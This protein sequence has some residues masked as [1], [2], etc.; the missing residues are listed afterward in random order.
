MKLSP[1]DIA[2]VDRIRENA[3][4]GIEKLSRSI[5]ELGQLY[6]VLIDSDDRLIDG[7]RR[8]R[9][10]EL[11]GI[12]VEC[13]KVIHLDDAILHLKAERD[14]NDTAVPFTKSEAVELGK[15]LELLEKPKAKERQGTRTD[16]EEHSGKLPESSKG[17]TRDKVAAAVGMSGKT[18]EK[19]KAVVEAA[20]KPGAPTEVKQAKEQMDRTGK[21]DPAYKTVARWEQG[22]SQLLPVSDHSDADSESDN[23]FTLKQ[24]WKKSSKKDRGKFLSWAKDQK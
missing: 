10:C 22:A 18:Y 16:I 19:A 7:A 23:L 4:I 2:V 8:L 1:T 15:R 13:K 14:T 5:R 12:D 20:A 3:D 17:D 9:A 21:V 11:L 24:T 6:P